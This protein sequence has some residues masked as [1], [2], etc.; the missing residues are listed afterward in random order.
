[1]IVLEHSPPLTRSLRDDQAHVYEFYVILTNTYSRGL[2]CKFDSQ[3]PFSI[4]A[5]EKIGGTRFDFLK[6]NCS[7]HHY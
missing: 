6:R 5:G 3:W 2:G 1:V 4:C 7:A